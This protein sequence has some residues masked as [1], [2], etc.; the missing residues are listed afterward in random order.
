[1][2][3][4]IYSVV[5]TLVL[6]L[7]VMAVH[8]DGALVRVERHPHI[9][10]LT[11]KACVPILLF[12]HI[13]DDVTNT[14][15]VSPAQFE[16]VITALDEAGFTTIDFDQLIAFVENGDPLPEKPLII[17]FDDGYESNVLLA[18]PVLR[19]HGMRATVFAIGVSVGKTLY[20]NT[21]LPMTPHFTWQQALGARDVLTVQSHTY[22][23]HQVLAYDSDDFRRGVLPK[24]GETAETHQAAFR[25]DFTKSKTEI[26]ENL[27]IPVTAFAYPYG[28]HTDQTDRILQEMGVKVTLLADDGVNIIATGAPDSLLSLTRTSVDEH[29]D[30]KALANDLTAVIDTHR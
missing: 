7:Q 3:K 26:E 1:M 28:L 22:D 16:A 20:K 27:K 18:A 4:L 12:H 23:M 11:Q 25:A 19:K 10:R 14:M 6:L 13:T 15:G 9:Q 30:P 2:K 24:E 8:T 21:E 17:T 5:T 29:T